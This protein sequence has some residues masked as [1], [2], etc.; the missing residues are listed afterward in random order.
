[1]LFVI[2]GYVGK[3]SRLEVW[4][5]DGWGTCFGKSFRISSPRYEFRDRLLR[6]TRG[7]NCRL[8]AGEEEEEEGV[9]STS[10]EVAEVRRD[11]R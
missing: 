10:Q 11:G 3:V 7:G 8:G 6:V 1:M 9:L 2:W 5:G 4:G